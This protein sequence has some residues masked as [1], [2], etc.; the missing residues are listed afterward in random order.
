MIEI[1]DYPAFANF[2]KNY[3]IEYT[4]NYAAQTVWYK[5]TESKENCRKLREEILSLKG[6]NISKVHDFWTNECRPECPPE[7]HKIGEILDTILEAL[8]SDCSMIQREDYPVF[9]YFYKQY[10]G[11]ICGNEKYTKRIIDSFKKYESDEQCRKLKEDILGLRKRKTWELEA[12]FAYYGDHSDRKYIDR[13]FS[14]V[15]EALE[16]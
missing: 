12:Y 5:G 3:M 11:D 10:K 15:L 13:Y 16:S 8:D 7:Q 4:T 14:R 2:I 6:R 1:K 9:S